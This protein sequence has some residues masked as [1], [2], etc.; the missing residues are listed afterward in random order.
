[1]N[2]AEKAGHDVVEAD[3]PQVELAR[4]IT[5]LRTATHGLGTYSW[6]HERFDAVPGKWTGPKA[7]AGG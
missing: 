1:M 4:Y 3:V 5:E 6:R 7:A 2:P